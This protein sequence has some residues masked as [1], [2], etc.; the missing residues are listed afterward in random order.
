MRYSR[1]PHTCLYC[2]VTFMVKKSHAARGIGK[3]CSRACKGAHKTR[4]TQEVIERRYG[5]PI[6]NVLDYLYNQREMPVREVAKTLGIS[7]RTF[8]DWIDDLNFQL[9][10]RSTAVAGQ[11]KNNN[12]RRRATAEHARTVF[13][14]YHKSGDENIARRPEVAKKISQSKTGRTIPALQGSRNH[15]WRGGKVDYRGP[16]WKPQ[17]EKAL[18]RDKYTCQYCGK[19]D[20]I[21]EVHHKVPFRVSHNNQLKN[22]IT[23]CQQCHHEAEVKW[24]REHPIEQRRL[25]LF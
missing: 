6:R 22:L 25:R 20:G 4:M 19:Q 5:V 24:E 21:L 13:A 3:F 2:G 11:W 18:Q 15:R 7:T 8:F 17:R 12:D 10:D 9:R 16:D 23:L 14:P 1:I